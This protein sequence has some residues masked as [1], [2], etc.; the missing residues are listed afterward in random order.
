[1]TTIPEGIP[2]NLSAEQYKS[3]IRKRLGDT[4]VDLFDLIETIILLYGI[5]IVEGE[6]YGA[7]V[8]CDKLKKYIHESTLNNI[9]LLVL[10]CDPN[11]AYEHASCNQ[12]I[13]KFRFYY[14]TVKGYGVLETK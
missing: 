14:D 2:K 11:I 3:E 13:E 1:M 5:N 4:E 6:S 10:E 7:I 12:L 8:I 9:L